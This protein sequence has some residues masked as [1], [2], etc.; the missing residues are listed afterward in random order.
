MA[1]MLSHRPDDLVI[2]PLAFYWKSFWQFPVRISLMLFMEILQ[3]CMLVML[4]YAVKNI[5][6]AAD[7]HDPLKG[8]MWDSIHD[9]FM[10]L[11]ALTLAM[12]A[13]SRISGAMLLYVARH[14]RRQPRI[15]LF[16]HLLKHSM[17]Y[18]SNRHSGA[19][20]A[21]IHDVTHGMAMA[22]WT[23]L[24]DFVGLFILF[25]A[26]AVTVGMVY[27][28][29]GLMILAWGVLYVTMVSLLTIP[30]IYW[31]ERVSRERANITGRI[32]DSVANVFSLKAY[33]QSAFEQDRL[34]AYMANE[35]KAVFRYGLWGEAIHWTHFILTFVLIVGSVYYSVSSY[36]A[37]NIELATISYLFTLVLVLSTHSRHLTW[38]LQAFME[39]VGQIRDGIHT[40]MCDHEIADK[41]KA[42]KLKIKKGTLAFDNIS[43]GYSG[44]GGKAVIDNLTLNVPAGQKLGLVGSSGAGKSTL[45]S[46]LLRF[47]EIDSG[48]IKIDG[49]ALADVTQDSLREAI[50]VIPQDTTLFHR[51]LADNI[52]YGCHDASDG[53]VIEAAKRAHAH[54][55][56]KDLPKGYET[57]VGE[58]GLKLSGGQ[59]QRIAIARAILK[60]APILV[61]DEATSALDSE[62]EQLIQDSLFEL[63]KGKTVIAIAHRLSTIAQLD[64]LVVME[65]GRIVEDGNHKALLKSKGH[66]AKLWKMQSGGFL[67]D[68]NV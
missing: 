15:W 25:V 13:F 29:M 10:M 55:F 28:P 12:A 66:Y 27:L 63:M 40:I 49:Q 7:N 4:P 32:I 3:A 22:T 44:Q 23:L 14:I 24:F 9:P 58:R 59:R 41:E 26:S 61:L 64:R 57:M 52:R 50:S 21:K 2:K 51:S 47:Y 67:G 18:F 42:G 35:E 31:I 45:V 8:T 1:G 34:G 5:V 19:L 17:E 60:N 43:F 68:E 53:D 46:L 38:S 20:G 11:V 62:S 65:Q 6:T 39:Y 30:R 54:D 37:G 33:A 36:E 56:I 16:E 48:T